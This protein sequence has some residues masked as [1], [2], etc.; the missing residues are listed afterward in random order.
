MRRHRSRRSGR[1]QRGTAAL[2]VTLLLVFAMLIVVAVA[3]RNA[4]VETR[5]SA[6]QYRSTQSFEAAEAGLEWALAR[7]NDNLP[8]GDDC[9]P[10][11]DPA[12]P[13]FRDRY[14]RDDGAG[15]LA[16]TG[17][18]A[19]TP[20]PL[21]ASCVRGDDGWSCSCPANGPA[22][23][24]EPEGT[25]TAPSFTLRFADGARL[26]IVRAIAT[27]C[28]RRGAPC[29][30]STEAG[31]EA[32]A[33]LEVALGLVAGLRAAPVAAL[34]VAGS[35]DAGLGAL[36]VHN[37]DAA[38][39]GIAI[40]AGGSVVG[41]ALRL[42]APAGS[43]LDGSVVSGDTQLAALTGDRFFARWFGGDRAA[44]S[45]QPAATGVG[46]A[47][48]CAA[49]IAGA[50]AG[51]SRLIAVDGDVA[52]DGPLDLGSPERPIV[53]LAT[54]ALRLR[55]AV[56]LH[57]VVV[58]G[59]LDWRDAAANTGALVRGAVL[60]EGSYQGDAA[61][62]LLHDATLLARLQRQTGSFARVNGSWKDF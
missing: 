17:D 11:A 38:S 12:A 25:A 20:V 59:S 52:L 30:A 28:T 18:D 32:A 55:G 9:L 16:A 46:C 50:V 54:G 3:N 56:R 42:S 49:G 13:S 10:S 40:H 8:I 24:A 5:A 15:F 34:T 33:R 62:D 6:N 58:A 14:L 43:P 37:R 1:G 2:V 35:I 44:W 21:Q 61:A 27:G 60:V 19:G 41:D 29:S 31:H 39:G 23:V 53:L 47:S 57:G 51:G 7:L 45:A 36:G 26:G 48:N 22:V 4:V